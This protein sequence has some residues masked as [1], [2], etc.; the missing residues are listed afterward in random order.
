MINRRE[1][2][3][4]TP[5]AALAASPVAFAAPPKFGMSRISFITDEASASPDDA[6]A[7]A[8][9]YGLKWVELRVVPGVNKGYS[10]LA[11]P[12][13]RDASRQIR[14][15]GLKVAFYNAGGTKYAL[16]GT[17]PQ[18]IAKLPV[19]WQERNAATFSKRLDQLKKDIAAAHIFGTPYVRVFA[20]GRV[21]DVPAL[22]PRL[23]EVMGEMGEVARQEGVM[24]LLENEPA[25]NIG[26]CAE[27]ASLIKLL[28]EK[29]V[30]LNW[31]ANNGQSMKEK[32]FPDGYALLPKNRIKHVHIHGRTLL[33]PE[34]T[35]DWGAIFAALDRDGYTG[36]AGLETHYFDGTKIEKSHLSMEA[37]Q[38]IFGVRS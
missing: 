6:I 32:P 3:A 18:N 24:L 34:K 17:E 20:F 33:D 29:T 28:P 23:A 27:M 38:R 5:T 2:L 13:L 1:F 37:L 11:E 16:P 14:E 19:G 8:A 26:S 30:G 7:F 10:S 21:A 9:K 35:L 15:A 22:L 31:D 36:C 25:C 12:E 4:L